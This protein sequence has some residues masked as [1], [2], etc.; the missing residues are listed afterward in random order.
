MGNWIYSQR[1]HLVGLGGWKSSVVTFIFT[2]L[3]CGLAKFKS[4]SLLTHLVI[5]GCYGS[6]MSMRMTGKQI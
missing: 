2:L 6:F 1:H 4:S 3:I 5:A